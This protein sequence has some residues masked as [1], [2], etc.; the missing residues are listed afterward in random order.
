MADQAG[1]ADCSP[2]IVVSSNLRDEIK[3]ELRA[4]PA[5]TIENENWK[6]GIGTSIRAG[7]RY[8]INCATNVDAAVLLVCDQPFVNSKTIRDLIT[9]Y[10]KTKKQIVASSY[11]GT[12]GVPALFDRSCFHELLALDGDSG[13][14]AIVLSN[15][16]RVA[17]LAFPDG[18]IDIDTIEQWNEIQRVTVPRNISAA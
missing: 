6:R 5:A 15:P 12:I 9:V 4:T 13:A 14:K 18:A 3:R 8:L 7:V 1:E 2:V 17:E 10:G 16:E 11:G